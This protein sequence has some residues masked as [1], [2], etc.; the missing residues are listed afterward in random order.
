LATEKRGKKNPNIPGWLTPSEVATRF[1]VTV[2]TVTDWCHYHKFPNA[3][4]V[5]ATGTG[6]VWLIPESDLAGFQKPGKP[7]VGRPR[8]QTAP[9]DNAT[10]KGLSDV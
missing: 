7:G 6:S 3:Q 9:A 5:A 10:C 2:R 8:K 1:N 4:E